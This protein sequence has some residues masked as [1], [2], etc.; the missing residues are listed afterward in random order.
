MRMRSKPE[1]GKIETQIRS[2]GQRGRD[3]EQER[4]IYSLRDL[5]TNQ[6]VK[7]LLTYFLGHFICLL[8]VAPQEKE[9]KVEWMFYENVKD[10]LNSWKHQMKEVK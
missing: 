5:P 1:G 6:Q 3:R 9:K 10:Q 7:Y 2:S 4:E 8:L